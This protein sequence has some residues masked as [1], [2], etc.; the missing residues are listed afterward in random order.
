MA[1]MG[2]KSWAALSLAGNPGQQEDAQTSGEFLS[3]S[4]S[5]PA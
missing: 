2:G 1:A 5:N 4:L 3:H